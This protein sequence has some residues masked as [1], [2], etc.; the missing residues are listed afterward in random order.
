MDEPLDQSDYPQ[1]RFW[2][3]QDWVEREK[4]HNDATTLA[5]GLS[6]DN[7]G[8]RRTGKN[9]SLQY[10]EYQDG[11]MIDGFRASEIRKFARSIWMHLANRGK[12]PKTW[13]KVDMESA[14]HYHQE[15]A[16]RFPELCLCA[17]NWK[18]DQIA[19]DNYPNWA[20]NN[21]VTKIKGED[22]GIG[23]ISTDTLL[24]KRPHQD[25]SSISSEEAASKRKRIS[26]QSLANP[27]PKNPNI[28]PTIQ[29]GELLFFCS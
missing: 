21:L 13:G 6:K 7:R 27:L 24:V 17:Y 19:T 1:I 10:I 22:N 26:Q 15:M 8:K 3:K 29:R 9:I 23:I 18:A 4:E 28:D 12:A 5:Q 14:K 16:R 20:I 2:F 11:T 25:Q